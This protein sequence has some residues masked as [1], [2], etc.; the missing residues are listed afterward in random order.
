MNFVV[1]ECRSFNAVLVKHATSQMERKRE[2]R[3]TGR[4]FIQ[5]AYFCGILLPKRRSEICSPEEKQNVRLKV[6]SMRPIGELWHTQLYSDL[7]YN[8]YQ[9]SSR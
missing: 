4:Y 3:G 8:Q 9:K 1:I 2:K 7:P 6:I 5:K